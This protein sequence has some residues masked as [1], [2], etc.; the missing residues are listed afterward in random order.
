MGRLQAGV[1]RYAS[2]AREIAHVLG[3]TPKPEIRFGQW[4]ITITFRRLG[5][6]RWPEAQ[7]M[8]FALRVAD[9]AR[10]AMAANRRGAVRSRAKH[11]IVVTY[12][13]VSNARGCAVVARW[14]CV[15]PAVAE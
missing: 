11:A 3:V 1:V 6:S 7:Q 9:E 8:D 13:D 15:I 5:A 4:R 12:E 10:S 2:V 14:E